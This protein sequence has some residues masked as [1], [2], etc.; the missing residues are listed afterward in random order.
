MHKPTVP[1]GLF[2]MRLARLG[3]GAEMGGTDHHDR[4]IGIPALLLRL[5]RAMRAE[6]ARC[7]QAHWTG[8]INRLAGLRA[9]FRTLWPLRH[10]CRRR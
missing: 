3:L 8:D 6:R 5:I 9:S 2:W 1:D 4:G 7:R 10:S